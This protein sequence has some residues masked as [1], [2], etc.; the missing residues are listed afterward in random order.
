[1]NVKF[2]ALIFALSFSTHAAAAQSES[3]T[4][5]NDV[6]ELAVEITQGQRGSRADFS[7]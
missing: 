1:M 7:I 4:E 3:S 2:A 5:P 6:P